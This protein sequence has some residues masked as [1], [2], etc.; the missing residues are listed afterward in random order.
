MLILQ[1]GHLDKRDLSHTFKLHKNPAR[2]P[3]ES[4]QPQAYGAGSGQGR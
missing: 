1:N 3:N 2:A 4:R